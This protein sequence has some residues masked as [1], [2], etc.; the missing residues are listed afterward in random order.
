M[1]EPGKLA[2]G[3]VGVV[4]GLLAGLGLFIF[5]MQQTGG[6][7]VATPTLGLLVVVLV[8]GGA[9]A[10]GYGAL[11]LVERIERGRKRASRKEKNRA[12]K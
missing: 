6:S 5:I 9:A 4:L 3:F 11:A 8:G 2:V 1:G 10:M 7:L 12:R